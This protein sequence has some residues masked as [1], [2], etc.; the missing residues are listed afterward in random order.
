MKKELFIQL[1]VLFVLTQTIGLIVADTLIK[2]EVTVTIITDNPD[3]IENSVGLFAYI[4]VVT[5]KTI[6]LV[7]K[8][9]RLSSPFKTQ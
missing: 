5:A 4:L 8:I 7:P 3:D 6:V 9:T 2:E 1:V